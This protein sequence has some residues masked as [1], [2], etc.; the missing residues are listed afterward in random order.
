[1]PLNN[2]NNLFE[3]ICLSGTQVSETDYSTTYKCSFKLNG[4]TKPWYVERITIPFEENKKR[5]LLSENKNIDFE[6]VYRAFGQHFTSVINKILAAQKEELPLSKS[7]NKLFAVN[8]STLEN[9]ATAYYLITAPAETAATMYLSNNVITFSKLLDL[10]SRLSQMCK[11]LAREDLHICSIDLNRIYIIPDENNK[12]IFKSGIDLFTTNIPKLEFVASLKSSS[13]KNDTKAPALFTPEYDAY[14]IFSFFW[15][16]ITSRPY[17]S[18]PSFNTIPTNLPSDFIQ[19]FQK[20]IEQPQTISLPQLQKAFYA[21]QK[22]LPQHQVN[23]EFQVFSSSSKSTY[24]ENMGLT[25]EFA[26][27][28]PAQINKNVGTEQNEDVAETSP[29]TNTSHSDNNENNNVTSSTLPSGKNHNTDM[30][31]KWTEVS[32]WTHNGFTYKVICCPNT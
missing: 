29:T 8:Q 25:M 2:Q 17:N 10:C 16:I 23:I 27:A 12:P 19:L 7:I 6:T 24:D 31:N 3:R 18:V 21:A 14:T 9:G 4:E 26:Q 1:M 15:N 30:E 22:V 28:A 32:S 11:G 20:F 5:R 13:I